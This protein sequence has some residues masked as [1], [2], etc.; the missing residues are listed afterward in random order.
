MSEVFG[1]FILSKEQDRYNG[2]FFNNKMKAFSREEIR[3]IE[4]S[5]QNDFIGN[6]DANWQEDSGSL[7]AVLQI[8]L[9]SDEIYMLTWTDVRLNGELQNVTFTGRGVLRNG[10]LVAVYSMHHLQYS[11]N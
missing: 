2:E 1:T 6:F 7:S 10:L 4:T 11:G 3:V 9:E 5:G 8:D